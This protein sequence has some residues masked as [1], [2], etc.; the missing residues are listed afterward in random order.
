MATAPVSSRLN[1]TRDQLAAF[2]TD[3]QQIRQFELLFSTVSAIA[4]NMSDKDFMQLMDNQILPSIKQTKGVAEVQ[5]IGGERR[6]FKIDIDGNWEADFTWNFKQVDNIF[7]DR[8]PPPDGR[9]GPFYA[10]DYSRMM[11]NT[12]KRARRIA[13]PNWDLETGRDDN[14]FGELLNEEDE[15]NKTIDFSFDYRYVN[16][17]KWNQ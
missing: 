6:E 16:K 11:S 3:Q 15:L 4:P 14:D 8:L 10:Q 1:L 5:V 2:L 13:K 12:A 9:K 17:G 7:D